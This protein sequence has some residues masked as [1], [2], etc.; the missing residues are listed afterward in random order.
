VPFFVTYLSKR[1]QGFGVLSLSV[2]FFPSLFLIILI[3]NSLA[4]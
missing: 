2:A 3:D 1:T 4:N